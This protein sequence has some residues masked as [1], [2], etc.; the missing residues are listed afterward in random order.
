MATN[1]FDDPV[2]VP[3]E[4]LRKLMLHSALASVFDSL[5][6]QPS[7]VRCI[8]IGR[9]VQEAIANPRCEEIVRS[10]G[11]MQCLREEA[12]ARSNGSSISFPALLPETA[13]C[14]REVSH[15]R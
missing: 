3:M 5:I 15:V 13:A 10:S 4:A 1:H 11:L 8:T 6:H 14:A 9:G 12:I 7:A 2:G